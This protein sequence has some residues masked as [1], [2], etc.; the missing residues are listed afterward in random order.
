MSGTL[1]GRG[2]SLTGSTELAIRAAAMSAGSWYEM[3]TIN[4]GSVFAS[5]GVSGNEL[6]Y[7][8]KGA[9]D[10]VRG[11]IHVLGADHWGGAAGHSINH[12]LYTEATNTWSRLE[13]NTGIL[14]HDY[15]H[16]AIDQST[17]ILYQA[18]YNTTKFHRKQ[19]GSS[20]ELNYS[21]AYPGA[22]SINFGFDFIPSGSFTGIAQ[23]SVF[24]YDKTFG[25]FWIFGLTSQTW[26]QNWFD[27]R[28]QKQYEDDG[29]TGAAYHQIASYS[30]G[31]NCVLLGGG[32]NF[33]KNIFRYNSD[34]TL[35]QLT[36]LSAN[37]NF[38]IYRGTLTPI[39]GTSKYL[40]I[41]AYPDSE[42]STQATHRLWEIDPAGS[43]TYTELASPPAAVAAPWNWTGA[44]RTD[45]LV[46]I[47]IAG[48]GYNVTMFVSAYGA[49]GTASVWLYKHTS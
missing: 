11:L 45:G 19:P 35:T 2:K 29:T 5:G 21:L 30:P 39:P 32:N 28:A 41:T 13:D 8:H 26:V 14:A 46:V 44:A 17:G 48:T 16:T 37:C 25:Q 6:P 3:T 38:G 10:P 4:A 42:A 12:M 49:T 34:H 20:W 36:D 31:A 23:P 15:D 43:G 27:V 1:F 9:W 18:G 40:N 24:V 7:M 33:N 22:S 47:P